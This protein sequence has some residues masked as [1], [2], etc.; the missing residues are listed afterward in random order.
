VILHRE[1]RQKYK[2]IGGKMLQNVYLQVVCQNIRIFAAEKPKIPRPRLCRHASIK[3]GVFSFNASFSSF[4]SINKQ[5]SSGKLT[6]NAKRTS[7]AV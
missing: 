5:A 4:S 1:R 3:A 7:G 2:N 6:G